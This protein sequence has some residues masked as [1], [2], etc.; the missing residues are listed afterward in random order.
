M[1][2]RK[3]DTRNNLLPLT[4]NTAFHTDFDTCSKI[5]LWYCQILS[6]K[7]VAIIRR[8]DK[9]FP[10]KVQLFTASP[11]WWR[12]TRHASFPH[13]NSQLAVQLL[14]VRTCL[15]LRLPCPGISFLLRHRLHFTYGRRSLA[16]RQLGEFWSLELVTT[17]FSPA[18][19]QWPIV[20]S[21][22]IS[23]QLCFLNLSKSTIINNLLV[24]GGGQ[25]TTTCY[26]GQ[27]RANFCENLQ[28]AV[29]NLWRCA[30]A[31]Y[32]RAACCWSTL[33][34]L[35]TVGGNN[36]L[37]SVHIKATWVKCRLELQ[38]IHRFSQSRRGPY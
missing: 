12:L 4:F 20:W 25:L 1:L 18:T 16:Y 32:R 26:N 10:A 9:T 29:S 21:C 35:E 19:A 17:H 23:V 5:A 24:R 7:M 3:T 27:L 2:I 38:M 31:L 28:W 15:S 8:L 37:C 34:P 13:L 11:A 14:L 22:K 36:L 6:S 33:L 30:S